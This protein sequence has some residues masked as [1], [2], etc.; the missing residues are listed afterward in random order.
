MSGWG[1]N[2][3][4]KIKDYWQSRARGRGQGKRRHGTSKRMT[5]RFMGTEALAICYQ[6]EGAR[7]TFAFRHLPSSPQRRCVHTDRLEELLIWLML[8]AWDVSMESC[9]E[10]I[11]NKW[12]YLIQH[13]YYLFVFRDII[14]GG[15]EL[16][17]S[18]EQR[19]NCFC[20]A[21]VTEFGY[22]LNTTCLFKDSKF[23]LPAP[24][25]WVLEFPTT[26]F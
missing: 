13:I 24:N 7:A 2:R 11:F 18:A 15:M 20:W 21:I 6:W 12:Q 25:F 1:E 4:T 16:S 23:L 10:N 9:D 22:F 3:E 26:F 14:T 19:Q 5:A 17:P 8:E